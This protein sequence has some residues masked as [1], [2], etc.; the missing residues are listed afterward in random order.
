MTSIKLM[1]H[2]QVPVLDTGVDL[3]LGI[4]DNICKSDAGGTLHTSHPSDFTLGQTQSWFSF[5]Y[6]SLPAES[7][8][9]EQSED[10]SS[11]HLADLISGSSV[12]NLGPRPKV[13]IKLMVGEGVE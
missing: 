1:Q 4:E 7:C 8:G 5:Y 9:K 13:K 12:T 6:S 11:R 10:Q 2:I 3:T